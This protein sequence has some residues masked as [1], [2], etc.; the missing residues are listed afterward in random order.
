VFEIALELLE[1]KWYPPDEGVAGKEVWIAS[2]FEE[3]GGLLTGLEATN[4]LDPGTLDPGLMPVMEVTKEGPL[5]LGPLNVGA[6]ETS[7]GR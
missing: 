4:P 5:G 2:V 1:G 6:L 7:G 3:A